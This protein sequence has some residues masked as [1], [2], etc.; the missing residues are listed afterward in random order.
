MTIVGTHRPQKIQLLEDPP[1]GAS[2]AH[3]RTIVET[4]DG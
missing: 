3:V 4:V 1:L 2:L